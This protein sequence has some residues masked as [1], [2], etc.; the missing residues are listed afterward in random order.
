MINPKN[1]DESDIFFMTLLL[2]VCTFIGYVIFSVTMASGHIEYCYMEHHTYPTGD[3]YTITGLR[4]WRPDVTVGH[5]STIEE[6]KEKMKV[7]CP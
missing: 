1:W 4:S 6:A 3:Q 7:F 5:A 2:I